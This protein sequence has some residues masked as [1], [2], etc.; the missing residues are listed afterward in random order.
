MREGRRVVHAVGRRDEGGRVDEE[1][2]ADRDALAAYVRHED[3][4]VRMRGVGLPV[5]DR[6]RRRRHREHDHNNSENPQRP[7]H[8]NF[9]ASRP[10]SFF[11]NSGTR[12]GMDRKKLLVVATARVE[13]GPLREAVREHAGDEAEIRVVA[14]ASDVSPLQWL[15]SDEDGARET[16]AAVASRLPRPSGP[17]AASTETEVGDAD[18]VQAIEDALRTSRQTRCSSSRARTTMRAGSSRTRRRRRASASAF[19]SPA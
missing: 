2:A 4:D 1:A 18:P 15:A 9:S 13:P 11:P 16:A 8:R 6:R 12:Y 19:R 5:Q 14:P 17:E 10:F 3:A 7:P